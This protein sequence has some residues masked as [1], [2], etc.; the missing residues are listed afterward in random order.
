M[1]RKTTVFTVSYENP[2]IPPNSEVYKLLAKSTFMELTRSF[3][4]PNF[5][6]KEYVFH[7]KQPDV[8]LTRNFYKN[9][10]K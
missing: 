1:D 9:Y 4:E 7:I 2:E 3:F 6:P 5:K 10:E 8:E